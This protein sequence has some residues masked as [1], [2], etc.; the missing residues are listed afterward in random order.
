[1]RTVIFLALRQLWARKVLSGI[2]MGA[3]SLGVLVLIAMSGIML[4]FRGKFLSNMLKVSPQVT[5]Y[6]REL[7]RDPP[8][9]QRGEP[10]LVAT[11]I[12]HEV[13][14][15]RVTRIKRPTE[16]MRA[17]EAMEGVVAA[18]PVV[19]GSAVMVKSLFLC[20]CLTREHR[21]PVVHAAAA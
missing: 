9:L 17:I 20:E 18:A 8:I 4:G 15:D 12:A 19:S 14:S 11:E 16:I 7:H 5:V 1:M 2:A 13:P 6:D 3:V 10:L 21:A